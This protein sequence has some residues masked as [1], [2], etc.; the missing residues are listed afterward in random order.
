MSTLLSTAIK[1]INPRWHSLAGTRSNRLAIHSSQQIPAANLQNSH[2]TLNH[3]SLQ[4]RSHQSSLDPATSWRYGRVSRNSLPTRG[5]RSK[6][7]PARHNRMTGTSAASSRNL[8]PNFVP[9][10]TPTLH[11]TNPRAI[12]LTASSEY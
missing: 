3:P 1:S 10:L 12:N 4:Y 7:S 8:S 9:I 5:R 6:T 2:P 11:S